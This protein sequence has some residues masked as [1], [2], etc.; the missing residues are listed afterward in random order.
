MKR[1]VDADDI[2]AMLADAAAM[3]L[4]AADVVACL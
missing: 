3:P 1:A 4:Y 2:F